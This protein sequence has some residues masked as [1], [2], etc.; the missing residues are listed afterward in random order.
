MTRSN[1]L[2]TFLFYSIFFDSSKIDSMKSHPLIISIRVNVATIRKR[3]ILVNMI[4]NNHKIL[5]ITFSKKKEKKKKKS[6]S[7]SLDIS[8]ITI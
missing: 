6:V 4:V 2:H 3:L 7:L 5:I 8:I 1:Y